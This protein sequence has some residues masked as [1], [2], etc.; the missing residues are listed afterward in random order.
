MVFYVFHFFL[1]IFL[2]I[3]KFIQWLIYYYYDFVT[4]KDVMET[5]ELSALQGTGIW[6]TNMCL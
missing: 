6:L 2:L 5:T 4:A 3:T 1:N